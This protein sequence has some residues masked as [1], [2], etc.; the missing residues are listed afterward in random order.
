MPWQSKRGIGMANF[1]RLFEPGHPKP[2][3]EDSQ[4]ISYEEKGERKLACRRQVW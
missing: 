3:S 1:E 2:F 4:D